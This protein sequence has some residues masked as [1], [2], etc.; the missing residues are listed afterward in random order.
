V[1]ARSGRFFRIFLGAMKAA[2]VLVPVSTQLITTVHFAAL[3]AA[4]DPC[5]GSA[6]L[7]ACD[8]EAFWLYT[9]ARPARPGGQQCAEPILNAACAGNNVLRRRQ[10]FGW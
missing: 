3:L 7:T 8:D 6:T 4:A 1:P 10:E 2:V 5:H 9:A